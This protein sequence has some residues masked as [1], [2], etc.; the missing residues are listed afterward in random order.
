MDMSTEEWITF[1]AFIKYVL[2]FR[3]KATMGA[4]SFH[5]LSHQNDE[6]FLCPKKRKVILFVPTDKRFTLLDTKRT[7]S[8]KDKKC[9]KK[10]TSS[11]SLSNGLSSNRYYSP[12]YPPHVRVKLCRTCKA[13][14][15]SR[16]HAFHVFYER[17]ICNLNISQKNTLETIPSWPLGAWKLYKFSFIHR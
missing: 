9:I 3:Q 17:K 14:K 2:K 5:F 8:N 15:S 7:F 16:I 4:D 10:G 12:K 1:I 6:Q 11:R 13:N